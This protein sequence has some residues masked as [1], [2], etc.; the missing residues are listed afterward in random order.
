MNTIDWDYILENFNDFDY[1]A[2]DAEDNYTEMIH[3]AIDEY[4]QYFDYDNKELVEKYGVFDAIS[5]YQ[6]NYGEFVFEK[7]KA[8]EQYASLAYI[9]IYEGFNDK[10]SF[11]KM[12]KEYEN[13]A[14]I[15]KKLANLSVCVN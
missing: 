8:F 15:E 10:Y 7:K 4:V 6:D 3:L 2:D 5:L 1:D 14:I 12:K 11:D 13:D 9:I